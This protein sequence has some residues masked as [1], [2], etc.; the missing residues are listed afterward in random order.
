MVSAIIL[1]AGESRRMESKNKLLLPFGHVT[2]IEQI[3]DT[4]LSSDVGEA[5][6]VLG[7]EAESVK[8]VLVNRSV[9]FVYN[10]NYQ[11]GMTTSI[12]V[13]VKAAS[14]QTDGYMICLSDLPLI[15]PDELNHLIQAFEKA[16]NENDKLIVIPIFEGQRGNPVIFSIHYKT[17]ILDHRGMM[18]CKGIVKQNP[19]QVLEIEMDT[20]HVLRDIDVIEDYERIISKQ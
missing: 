19:N 8:N 11:A 2:L 10:D 20:D 14:S 7:H 3:V 16:I 18:G 4:V 6:V 5:V 13:G 9:K 15:E 17:D 1:A 12:H